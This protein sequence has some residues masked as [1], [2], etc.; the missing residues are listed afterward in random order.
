MGIRFTNNSMNTVSVYVDETPCVKLEPKQSC[1]TDISTDVAHRVMLKTE[2]ESY[3]DW[4]G[5][6]NLNVAA[7][8]YLSNIGECCE[9]YV[10]QVKIESNINVN[11][12]KAQ[13]NASA[14][15]CVMAS[16]WVADSQ[17][18]MKK[19]NRS[20]YADIFFFDP[21]FTSFGEVFIAVLIG[22]AVFYFFGWKVGLG[23]TLATYGF[24]VA[25]NY[26]IDKSTNVI[27]KKLFKVK[28][29]DDKKDFSDFLDEDYLF[30]YLNNPIRE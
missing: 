4:K 1:Q 21:L 29:S 27:F 16:C 11:L 3:K 14:A 6:Y 25:L 26:L 28:V 20:R 22:I 17:D 9:C 2:K 24:L 12:L 19:H 13:L 18:I 30:A 8:F 5:F 10:T 23:Y 7:E 15:D